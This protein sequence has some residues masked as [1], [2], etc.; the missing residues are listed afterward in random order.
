MKLKCNIE[1]LAASKGMNL[2]Q[3]AEK[4]DVSRQTLSTIKNRC[5]CKA[6]TAYKLAAALDVDVTEILQED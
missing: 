1:V 4:A 3:L 5:T 6:L 2:S